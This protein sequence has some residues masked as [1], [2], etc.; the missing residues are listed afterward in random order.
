MTVTCAEKCAYCKKERI[1]EHPSFP[2]YSL[3]VHRINT[4]GRV[5]SWIC[6]DCRWAVDTCFL[7]F[8][9][10]EGCQECRDE[11]EAAAS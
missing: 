5:C 7:H 8:Q 9:D 10:C 3:T 6:W 1:E 4:E 2:W 11:Y